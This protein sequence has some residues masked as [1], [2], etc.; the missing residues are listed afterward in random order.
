MDHIQQAPKSPPHVEYDYGLRVNILEDGEESTGK[1][2]NLDCVA[3][4][5]F[6]ESVH[7]TKPTTTLL[8]PVKI[9]GSI[10][11]MTTPK[12]MPERFWGESSQIWSLPTN[13]NVTR[14]PKEFGK[15]TEIVAITTMINEE[16]GVMGW[17][18]NGHSGVFG[19][20]C[21]ICDEYLTEDEPQEKQ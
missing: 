10:H 14:F 15:H 7:K 3:Q 2:Y 6:E 13:D 11:F 20:K 18:C 9:N 1:T 21:P 19:I 5:N 12:H 8:M 16:A 17:D 4:Q